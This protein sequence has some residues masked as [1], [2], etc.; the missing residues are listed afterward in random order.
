LLRCLE[1]AH[2]SALEDHV[3]RPSP[4]DSHRSGILRIGI[5]PQNPTGPV[6]PLTREAW[7]APPCRFPLPWFQPRLGR[8][9]PGHPRAM[10]AEWDY[11]VRKLVWAADGRIK[12]GHMWPGPSPGHDGGRESVSS[13]VAMRH[14]NPH[15]FRRRTS[16]CV[17]SVSHTRGAVQS[18]RPCCQS[19]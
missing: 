16:V 14:G 7:M 3:H 10:V 4:M 13:A 6:H 17:I 15:C 5:S 2:E 12:S 1:Q 9:C 11:I 19:R 8:A 18:V